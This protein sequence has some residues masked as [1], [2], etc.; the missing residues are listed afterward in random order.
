MRRVAFTSVLLVM[1]AV[2]S[3]ASVTTPGVRGEHVW[4]KSRITSAANLPVAEKRLSPKRNA[5][6][7]QLVPPSFN[8]DPTPFLTE[9]YGPAKSTPKTSPPRAEVP[10]SA[11][12]AS[13]S[14]AD[15]SSVVR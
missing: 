9:F 5:T 2:A 11:P 15:Q 12:E 6:Q 10:V 14:P 3:P 4:T 13:V 1:A 7:P 8:A